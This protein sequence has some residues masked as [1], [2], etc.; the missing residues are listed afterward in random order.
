MPTSITQNN[1]L[2]T[3][4]QDNPIITVT[5]NNRGTTVDVTQVDITT[6]TVATPGPRGDK[7]APGDVTSG[8][9][10]TFEDIS[11]HHITASGN[12]TA[13]GHLGGDHLYVDELNTRLSNFSGTPAFNAG[14]TIDGTNINGEVTN[15]YLINTNADLRN[16]TLDRFGAGNGYLNVK[17]HITASGNIS[18]SGKFIGDG[19]GI[20][21][22]SPDGIV[23][24]NLSRIASNTATASISTTELNVNTN[25]SGSSIS[26]STDIYAVG[27]ISASGG[28]FGQQAHVDQVQSTENQMTYVQLQ[29]DRISFIVDEDDIMALRTDLA[30]TKVKIYHPTDI[31]GD[32]TA[33]GNIRTTGGYISASGNIMAVGTLS[34]SNLSGTNTGDQDLSSYI[35][36]SDT[37]SFIQNSNTS[38][39][40][41]ISGSHLTTASFGTIN[42]ARDIHAENLFLSKVP[43]AFIHA[44]EGIT[45]NFEHVSTTGNNSFKINRAG[46]NTAFEVNDLGQ[47]YVGSG[48]ANFSSAGNITFQIDNDYDEND[49]H[50]KFEALTSNMTKVT[51]LKFNES[52]SFE[53]NGSISASGDISSSGKLIASNLSGT[54]TGDQNITNLAV[55]GSDVIF[56]SITASSDISASGDLYVDDIYINGLQVIEN[57]SNEYIFGP[58]VGGGNTVTLQGDQITLLG[59]N[60]TASGE[61]SASGTVTVNKIDSNS[62][63]GNNHFETHIKLATD[64][65]VA[66][67]T[68]NEKITGDGTNLTL[69]ADGNI[70][71]TSTTGVDITGPVTASNDIS[72]SG[73]ITANSIVGTLATAAQP[74]ITSLG[75]LTSVCAG[76]ALIQL[77]GSNDFVNLQK[78]SITASSDISASGKII[79][80]PELHYNTASLSATGNAQGDIIKFGN[81]TTTAGL[82]YAH[83]G[84][85]WILA[86]S[87]ST[88]NGHG[89]SSLGMAIGTNSSN[90]GMLLRGVMNSGYAIGDLGPGGCALYLGAG[91]RVDDTPP[92]T[93]GHIARVVGW[94]FGGNAIYFTPDNTW[95]VI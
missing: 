74:N 95:V 68:V 75:T 16:L 88:S 94:N 23:G 28:L 34:G 85:G 19:S 6:V 77:G 33:S 35:Q 83:T 42:A 5:D 71:L 4:S 78:G 31:T 73:T 17:G 70:N 52:G 18:A 76:L 10:V 1:N 61:I 47:V 15:L 59:G 53:F 82:I 37:S 9:S 87:G 72:S 67:G 86:H 30:Y 36:N 21:N 41:D 89:S 81:T 84:S 65:S 63:T 49:Q 91:G 26:S 13:S 40:G 69:N 24:L 27:N 3:I 57:T 90:D 79:A 11:A 38:S 54:N 25:I 20:T 7:G 62:T 55:T 29:N 56:T 92:A 50:F 43:T 12:I 80:T 64:K 60:V 66:F 93:S 8:Q 32:V 44:A 58:Q 45:I 39:F 46:G 22:I 51:L 48:D 2:I 14:M